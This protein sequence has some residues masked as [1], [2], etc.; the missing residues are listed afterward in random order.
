MTVELRDGSRYH[1]YHYNN[2]DT[3]K[4]SPENVSAVEIRA[5]LGSIDSLRKTP[6]VVR[7]YRGIT[8]GAYH[9]EFVDCASG[10]RWEFYS[11]LRSLAERSMLPFQPASDSTAR[12]V[13]EIVG[14]L[15]PEWL[16]RR[17]NS[18]YTRVL[19]IYRLMSVRRAL[20]GRCPAR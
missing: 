15:T 19:H 3:R 6:D 4:P 17:W 11:E 5:A 10:A 7:T 13:V 12:Y 9:S 2:P 20:D 8:T 14:E 1:A 18:K 16:A